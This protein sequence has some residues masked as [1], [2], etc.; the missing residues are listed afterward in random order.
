MEHD[1]YP[2]SFYKKG[3][4]K[5]LKFKVLFVRITPVKAKSSH[6]QW[7][8]FY[9]YLSIIRYLFAILCKFYFNGKLYFIELYTSKKQTYGRFSQ[10]LH[11]VIRV[12][13]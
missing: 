13:C 5:V 12:F 8:Y 2:L 3:K 4:T 10:K 7:R 9:D 6:P 11:D 1:I